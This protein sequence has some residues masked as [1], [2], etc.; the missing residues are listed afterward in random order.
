[1]ALIVIS[2]FILIL[3]YFYISIKENSFINVFTPKLII[4][5]PANYILVLIYNS[6]NDYT[7][8]YNIGF[9][10]VY[11]TYLF[12]FATSMFVYSLNYRV[13]PL[14]LPSTQ[15]LIYS[16]KLKIFAIMSFLI[17]II[18]YSPVL[19]TFR[20]YIFHP[21]EIYVHTRDGGG[22][23]YFSSLFFLNIGFVLSLFAF[24][25]KFFIIFLLFLSLAFLHGSKGAM[26]WGVLVYMLFQIYFLDKYYS[27]RKTLLFMFIFFIIM[28][29]VFLTTFTDASSISNLVVKMASYSDYTRNTIDLINHYSSYFN[30]YWYGQLT[31]EENVYNKI[32]RI[33]YED[34]PRAFGGFRLAQAVYPDWFS[35]N[36]GDASFGILGRPFADFGYFAIFYLIVIGAIEGFLLKISVQLFRK[37]KNIFYFILLLFFTDLGFIPLGTGYLLMTHLFLA[38]LLVYVITIK[39]SNKRVQHVV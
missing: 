32:P 20:E 39:F 36:I 5:L 31:L 37:N 9:V 23:F 2:F 7:I 10:Y 15:S 1:M 3:L 16:D 12:Y 27:I 34:K 4:F 6:V 25:K 11:V 14:T 24:R 17:S 29:I 38:L 22:L 19:I 18:I 21:R 13:K 35:K 8:E 30:H 26:I 28:L 33:I